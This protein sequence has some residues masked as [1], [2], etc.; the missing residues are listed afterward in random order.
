M[1]VAD[2]ARDDEG[3]AV[4]IGG[5]RDGAALHLAAQVAE[6]REDAL[7]LFRG[8]DE[9]VAGDDAALEDLNV[10][11]DGGRGGARRQQGPE[12][13]AQDRGVAREVGRYRQPA[14]CLLHHEGERPG[15]RIRQEGVL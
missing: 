5:L 7:L 10:G 15:Q 1:L 4:E 12:R 9:L 6:G 11:G 2:G 14:P 8:R 3:H 13:I